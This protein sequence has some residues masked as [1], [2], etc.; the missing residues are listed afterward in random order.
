MTFVKKTSII[1]FALLVGGMLAPGALASEDEAGLPDEPGV[2]KQQQRQVQMASNAPIA[3][4]SASATVPIEEGRQT[5]RILYVIPNFRSVS[6]DEQLPPQSVK[7]KFKTATE[8]SLDYSAFIFVAGQ[9]GVAQANKSYPEF[10]QGTKG[11]AR[12]YW[13]TLADE[14]NENTW[15]EFIIPAVLHQDTRFYTLGRGNFGKRL[16]YAFTRILITRNDDGH[17]TFQLQRSGGCGHLCRRGELV[18]SQPGAHRSEELPAVGHES[19]NRWRD[20]RV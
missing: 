10:H 3:P 18:L 2:T 12:Y 5:K 8:D 19:G 15:V 1:A 6:T 9:A 17:Q 13:H 14:V 20:V 7:D 4:G 11:Y 16:G